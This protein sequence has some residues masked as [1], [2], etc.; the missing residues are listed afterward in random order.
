MQKVIANVNL[1]AIQNNAKAFKTLTKTRLLAVVKAN[2]YGHGAEEV[3]ACLSNIADGFAVALI[4]EAIAIRLA[5][6]GKEILVFTPP[7]DEKEVYAL[8]VNAFTATVPDLWTA[9]LIADVC[10][11]RRLHIRVHLK[12]NTGMNRYGMN[13]SMLGKVCKL[14]QNHPFIEVGGVY[15]HLYT[16]TKTVAEAQRA[17]FV[18]AEQI[19][20]RRYPNAVAH[21]SATYGGL[22][23]E[24]FAFDGVR[25]GLGLYGYLPTPTDTGKAA[26]DLHL[27][28]AMTVQTKV[29]ATR[30]A[31]YGGAGY[32]A[33]CIDKVQN[34]SVLRVGYADGFLR[35]KRGGLLSANDKSQALCMDAC[36]VNGRKKRGEAI[37][38]LSNA[39]EQATAAGTISYEVLCAA[40]RR[41]EIR[42][43]YE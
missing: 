26:N 24:E 17:L 23:G 18:R 3:T 29:T 10:Q 1:T 6:C 21:L 16:C 7:M 14:L 22:L 2:A 33:P 41:A 42:Y 43:G 20:K 9:R 12:V 35:D 37:V 32:G 30:K 11:K 36:I 8:A 40:T 13:L 39:E 15:S 34:L 27:Q 38:V 28:R 31:S 25:I 19:V 4:D 5:A